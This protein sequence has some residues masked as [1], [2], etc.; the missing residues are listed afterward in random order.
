VEASAVELGSP[1]V[2]RT[3]TAA[4]S[5]TVVSWGGA[6]ALL[7][8]VVWLVPI[9]NYRLPVNLPFSLE[10]YRLLILVY[11]VVWMTAVVSG[12][13]RVEAG[14]LGKPI[15]L[16]TTV[17]V[18]SLAS[19]A[20]ALANGNLT[21]QAV[22]SLSYFLSFLVAFLLVHSTVRTL[23]AI[24]YVLYALVLGA[25]L[26]SFAAFYEARTHYNLFH[27]LQ[28]WFFFLKP[29][30]VF[31]E[32]NRI[33]GGRLRVSASAQHP[34]ALGAALTMTV[35][36]AFYLA[37]RAADTIRARCWLVCG[38]IIMAGAATTVSRTVVL[39]FGVMLVVALFLRGFSLERQWPVLVAML[40]VVHFAAP[41]AIKHLYGAFFPKGGLSSQLNARVGE[42]G[43][44]RLSDVPAGFRSLGQA[45]V[46]GHGFGTSRVRGTILANGPGVITDPKTK[47]PIIFDDQWMNT[48]VTIGVLGFIGVAWFI[49]GGVLKLVRAARHTAGRVSDLVAA[50]AVSTAGFAA[51]MFA[52]DAFSF[53][54]C[55]LIFFVLMALGLRART[56]LE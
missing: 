13:M 4:T 55:T 12:K 8:F 32:T 53:V 37:S 41:G 27:H 46:F 5:E 30:R 43:S 16:M 23:P 36:L 54:Q 39:M 11:I 9:K 7:A 51:G 26:V 34:I 45:P 29:A 44:G 22:K 14:G 38:F 2:G 31:T 19:N 56:L 47:A 33:R 25:V 17:G 15:A 6:I 28:N 42:V 24:E 1:G 48:L 49:W 20:N 40:V 35:P 52:F 10:L 21:G 3:R 18:L 50:C